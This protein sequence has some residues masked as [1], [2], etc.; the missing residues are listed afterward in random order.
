M[1][2]VE[3]RVMSQITMI[4]EELLLVVQVIDKGVGMNEAEI[5]RVFEPFYKASNQQRMNPMGVGIGL[6]ICK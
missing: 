5:L 1:I 4:G 3:A 2:R 6:T